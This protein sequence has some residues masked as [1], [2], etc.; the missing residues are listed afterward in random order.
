MRKSGFIEDKNGIWLKGNLHSHSVFSDGNWTPE[1]LKE[2]YQK[3]GYDFLAITDH[4]IYVDTRYLSDERFTM[5]QGYEL[6]G[7]SQTDDE[8]PSHI[9]FLWAGEME[10]I[11]G[12]EK[13][14]LKQRTSKLC[15]ERCYEMRG[16]GAYVMLNH[17]HWSH[18]VST[19]VQD[20]NPY[21]AVEIINYATDWLQGVGNSKVFWTDLLYRGLKLWNGGSDDNHN[22]YS[23]ID[24][25]DNA[26]SDSFGGFTIV[27]AA[28][29]SDKAIID[30]L[31]RGS[32]YTSTGPSI[33]EFYIE[34]E[35][36]HVKCSP[37]VRILLNGEGWQCQQKI[38]RY[39]TECTFP[40][41][42]TEKFV[43]M[44]CMDQ[45][46]RSAYSNPIWLE[47]TE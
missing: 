2:Q 6:W 31:K 17:P 33:Y 9:N 42:G 1:Q 32:F 12:G 28:D 34:D 41:K 4:D 44:E 24:N 36:V 27:K 3:H 11:V 26:Y 29:R 46:G 39:L 21:H 14:P 38:G 8:H 23:P 30:A 45:A 37:C 5:L 16:K 19:D 10:G 20:E 40:L 47:D 18:L 22:R 35:V 7:R 25:V 13:Q 15:M 43:R